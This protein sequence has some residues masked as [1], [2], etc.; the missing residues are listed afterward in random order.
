MISHETVNTGVSPPISLHR[1]PVLMM[2]GRMRRITLLL[3]IILLCSISGCVQQNT[4]FVVKPAAFVVNPDI[5]ADENTSEVTM[6]LQG[7]MLVSFPWTPEDGRYW[8]VSVTEGL[9]VTGD[10]YIPY[11]PD[12]P[13]DVSGEREWMVKAISPG[14][15][16]FIGNL[17]PRT[18]SWNQE[19][20]Q[21]QIVV[22]VRDREPG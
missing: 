7:T 22:H 11:P 14:T 20:V 18:G 2:P 13:V 16:T 4:G 12:I 6:P 1:A 5:L 3:I 9:F 17:R 15:Q 19:V 10:R 8:R 21:K